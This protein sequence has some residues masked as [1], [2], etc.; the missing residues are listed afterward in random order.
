MSG[1]Q[2]EQRAANLWE[3]PVERV[4]RVEAPVERVEPKENNHG[5]NDEPAG[6]AGVRRLGRVR[7]GVV[8][9]TAALMVPRSEG[10]LW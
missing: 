3:P 1:T 10:Y 8:E 6:V 2:F 7:G 5:G 9:P 4:E